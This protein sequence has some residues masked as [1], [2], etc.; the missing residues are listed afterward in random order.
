MRAL[1]QRV[2]S[3]QVSVE[4]RMAA[5]IN[6]GLLIFVGVGKDDGLDDVEKVSRKIRYL[7]IFEDK[8]GKMNLDIMQVKGETLSIPQFTLYADIK[9]GNRPG[10][11]LAAEPEKAKELW[12]CFN[13]RLRETGI[14]VKEGIFGSHMDIKLV[15]DGPVTIWLDSQLL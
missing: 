11:E 3:A 15:N 9:S 7:R 4:N 5:F 14:Q 12:M 2:K 1:I 10:F 8:K 6:K 13:N